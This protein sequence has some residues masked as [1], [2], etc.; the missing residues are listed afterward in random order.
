M[1]KKI[2]ETIKNF[3]YLKQPIKLSEHFYITEEETP[4]GNMIKL[5]PKGNSK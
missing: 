4:E 3:M 1:I 2:L 5:I